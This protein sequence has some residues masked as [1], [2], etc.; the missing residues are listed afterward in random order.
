MTI[1]WLTTGVNPRRVHEPSGWKLHA[2]VAEDSDN[3][4]T[5]KNYR[6]TC[7]LRPRHGWDIDLFIEDRCKHC[8]RMLGLDLGGK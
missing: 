6:A 5:I 3:F 8:E 4:T 2:V 7:G 1:Q